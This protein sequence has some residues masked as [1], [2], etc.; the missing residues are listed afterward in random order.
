MTTEPVTSAPM[1]KSPG[2]VVEPVEPKVTRR[3]RLWSRLRAVP[4]VRW[5][6]AAVACLLLSATVMVIV[7]LD[8]SPWAFAGAALAWAG[9]LVYY[10]AGL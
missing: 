5:V 8:G 4:L 1:L 2:V 3:S 6:W 10:A 7:A 9:L